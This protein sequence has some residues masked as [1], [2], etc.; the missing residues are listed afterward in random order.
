MQA[1]KPDNQLQSTNMKANY[2]GDD[3]LP[4]ETSRKS[5]WCLILLQK[6]VEIV[7]RINDN[8]TGVN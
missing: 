6:G 8:D 7:I 5:H 4:S 2:K 3:K 1:N